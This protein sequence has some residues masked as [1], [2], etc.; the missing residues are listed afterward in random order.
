VNSTVE[1]EGITWDHERGRDP[2]LATAER[3][4]AGTGIRVNWTAR[5]LQAF[6]DAPIPVLAERYDLLVLDHP[7]LG[8]IVPTGAL[9]PLDDLLDRDFIADQARSSVGPS[10]AS[11]EWDGHLWA[12]AIDAAGHVSA[13][14]PDLLER[15]GVEVPETWDDVLVVNEAARAAGMSISLPNKAVDTLA[16]LLTLLANSGTDPY[17]D[18][19]QLAPRSVAVEKLVLL[20]HLTE[21][22]PSEAFA[23]NPILLLEHMAEHDDVAYCPILFGYSNYSR[24][25]FRRSLVRFRPVPSAGL[26]PCGGVIGG[27]GLSVSSRCRELEAA[28]A[29]AEYVA[30]PEVQRTLYVEAGGQPGHREAWIDPHA[31]ELSRSYFA[32]TLPGL[33][34]GYL[35]PRYEGALLVQNDGGKMV[36]ESLRSGGDPSDLLDRLD[37]LYRRSLAGH[38]G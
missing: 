15:L 5:S 13:Y 26:G 2:L 22:G 37:G 10:H 18:G 1:L 29:Y 12:L 34:A 20:A 3:F 4:E 11:Y 16:S 9:L 23:W 36:W 19:E 33:D 25:G 32:D 17:Q 14:R 21:A 35:R 28:R 31:N 38:D 8:E 27:A 30:S 7:H 24:P 6:A